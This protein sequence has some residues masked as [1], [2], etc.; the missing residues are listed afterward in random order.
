MKNY[1]QNKDYV[2]R[3]KE[4]KIKRIPLDVQ[5]EFYEQELK[6]LCLKLN[7]PINTFI[8]QAIS[9]KIEREQLNNHLIE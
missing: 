2:Y 7:M 5:I 4:K 1:E 8:K 3:Y 6:P 9:E